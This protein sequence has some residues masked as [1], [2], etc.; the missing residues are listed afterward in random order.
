MNIL[1]VDD[2]VLFREGLCNVLSKQPDL[3]VIGEAGTAAEAVEKAFK[4]KPDL[5]LMDIGLP[6]GTGIDAMKAILAKLPETK[7][8]ILTMYESDDL[9]FSAIR[10]GAKGYIYKNIPVNKLLASL[11]ALSQGQAAFSRTMTARIL[12]EFARLG[13]IHKVNGEGINMLS[14]REL[15]VLELVG[16]GASNREIA[17]SL[18]ISENTVKIHVHNVLDKLKLKNRQEA[19]TFA[20]RH[21]LGGPRLDDGPPSSSD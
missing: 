19:A 14:S 16:T 3:Q 15:E 1:I 6:D 18:Y 4:L 21:E 2:H 7:V 12:D 13:A 11:R 20:R 5:V 17:E 9:L 10:F 8:V